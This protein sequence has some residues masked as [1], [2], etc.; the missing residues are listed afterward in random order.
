MSNLRARDGAR[1]AIK[2]AWWMTAF[3]AG[4]IGLGLSSSCAAGGANDGD[5]GAGGDGASLGLD[6]GVGGTAVNPDAA[7]ASAS[8]SATLVPINMLVMIDKSM[9]MALMWADATSAMQSFFSDPESAGLRVALRFFP[10]T[11]CD[12]DCNVGACSQPKVPLGELSSLAAPDDGHE[13]ALID[14]FVGVEVG[15]GNTPLSAALEGAL[16]WASNHLTAHPSEKAAVVL[17]TDGEPEACNQN[18]GYLVSLA[19]AAFDTAGVLTFSIGLPGTD[20]ALMH[21]IAAA[22]GTGQAIIVGSGNEQQELRDAL[23]LVRGN[24]VACEFLVPGEVDGQEVDPTR[25]NVFYSPGG[26][27]ESQLI[28]QVSG[29]GDCVAT[30]QA[31]Y[32]D[33]PNNPT[34]VIFCDFTCAAIRSDPDAKIDVLFGC[35]T[36]PA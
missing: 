16:L 24:T 28:G 19:Q 21:Q 14:A 18:H 1:P 36:V 5:G 25:V 6:A 34:R 20:E 12:S 26:V 13:R 22:G 33:D 32:Y 30:Q 4:V 15:G 31:W 23:A 3:I 17:V 27:G 8:D 2:P 10:D 11:G 29:V 9:S 35:S 7:C